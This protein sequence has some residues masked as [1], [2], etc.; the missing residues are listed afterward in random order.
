MLIARDRVLVPDGQP[1]GSL[2][3][4]VDYVEWVDVVARTFAAMRTG[5]ARIVGLEELRAELGLGPEAGDAI[6]TALRDL[7]RLGI[8]DLD[9]VQWIKE[10]GNTRRLR[11]GARLEG[12][13]P[14]FFERYLE[15]DEEVSFPR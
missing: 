4:D 15:P 11:G 10:T 5:T 6:Y 8:V 14:A 1:Q 9:S 13:W 3:H 7:D 12:L 2:E